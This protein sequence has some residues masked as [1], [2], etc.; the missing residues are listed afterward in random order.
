MTAPSTSTQR[1]E[2]NL[3]ARAAASRAAVRARAP[4]S[5]PDL[6]GI[7]DTLRQTELFAELALDE[8][9]AL[10]GICSEQEV[11]KHAQVFRRGDPLWFNRRGTGTRSEL[12]QCLV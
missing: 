5:E 6:G 8:L 4:R 11:P 7:C 2:S 10:A 12:S 1:A 9:R 3:A